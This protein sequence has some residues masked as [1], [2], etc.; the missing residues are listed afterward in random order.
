MGWMPL[1]PDGVAICRVCGVD[2][3]AEGGGSMRVATM[4]RVDLARNV[5][6][7]HGAAADGSVPFRKKL[8]RPQFTASE[9]LSPSA[10]R[11]PG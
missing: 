3:E 6:R 2:A 11:L 1:S 10:S 5:F 8:S 9:G 4:I 7:V